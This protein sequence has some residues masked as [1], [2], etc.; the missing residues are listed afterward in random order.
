M[1]LSLFGQCER[2][3]YGPYEKQELYIAPAITL[4]GTFIAVE[5]VNGA[6]ASVKQRDLTALTGMA[7]TAGVTYVDYR[8]KKKKR[9]RRMGW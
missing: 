4:V 3:K 7:I 5:L 2:Y 1:T 8:I 9:Q 6:G